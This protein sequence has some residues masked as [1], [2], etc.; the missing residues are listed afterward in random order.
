MH[1]KNRFSIGLIFF[2]QMVIRHDFIGKHAVAT[3]VSGAFCT[4]NMAVATKH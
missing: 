4:A 3:P 1:I 2:M